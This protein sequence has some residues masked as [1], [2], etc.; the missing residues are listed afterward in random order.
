MTRTIAVALYWLA[1][2]T[3]TL[4]AYGHGFVGVK[5]VRAAI[6]ASALA[7]DIVRV[8][9]VVWYFVSGCMIA[10]GLLLFWAWP[11]LRAG[12]S[13]RSGVALIVGALYLVT[14]VA[15][16]QYTERDPFWLLFVIQGVIV[17]GSTLVLG[18]PKRPKRL[19]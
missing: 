6:E 7:P 5:P 10:F 16:F 15:S 17:I 4:G 11:A 14:G 12:T 3:I 2:I 19:E 18:R 9:W 8:I 13:S 1:A